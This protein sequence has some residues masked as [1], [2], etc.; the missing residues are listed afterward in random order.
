MKELKVLSI[1][2]TRPEAIKMAPVVRELQRRANVLS[3]VCV[4]GQHR[5]MLDQVLNLFNIVPDYDLNV[6]RADQTPTR[7]ITQVLLELDPLL[8]DIR[9]DW[10]LVQGDATTVMASAIAARHLK[11]KIGHVEAGLRT[12]DMQNPFPEEMNRVV[13]DAI[14][15][16]HFA[17][18]SQSRDN[19]LRAGIAEHSITVTGNTVIDALLDVANRP[20]NP[21]PNHPLYKWYDPNSRLALPKFILITAHRRESFGKPLLNICA[22][23]REIARRGQSVLHLIYP[24]HLN[25]NVHEPVKHLLGGVP[26]ITLTPPLDYLSLVHLMK[27]STLI[28]T[29]S[30][31]IQEEAPS[32][33]VPVI[34]LR[35]VTERP[36][37]I[38]AG[39]VKMVGTDP[40]KIVGETFRLLEDPRA[41]QAMAKA[42][43]PYGDGHAA[44]RIADK[45]LESA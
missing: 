29:D 15:D 30:G 43:N 18:T 40:E 4:T 9:P 32:L 27:H 8:R 38:Q 12:G 22:G 7:I 1:F 39:V 21:E 28:L 5:E 13:T 25:P 36:E 10:I 24:V 2:G 20:W 37:G 31:G 11:I 17:P 45:L 41:Y 14:S 16:L 42:V 33:G 23:L 44:R 35:D 3:Q 34:V 26:N 19:L 6:M